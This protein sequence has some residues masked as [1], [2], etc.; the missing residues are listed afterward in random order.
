[1][2]NQPPR[3]TRDH[4]PE[5]IIRRGYVIN[6][7]KSI[8]FAYGFGALETPVFENF[9]VLAVKGGLGEDVKNQIFYFKDKANRELGLR[10]DLTVGMARIVASNPQLPKPFKRYYI[11][12]AWRYE[13][14][15]AGRKR[16][17]VQADIDIVGT[18][19]ME[20]EVECM[21][22]A[23]DCL[24][25]LGFESFTILINNRKI[26]GGLL[27]LAEIPEEITLDT[28][29][30]IDKL[31]KIGEGGVNEELKSLGMGDKQIEKILKLI[32][33]TG[34]CEEVLEKS[35]KMLKGIK[36]AEDGLK[37]MEKIFEF[38]KVYGISDFLVFDL[39]L[40][41]GLDY[42]TGPIFEIKIKTEKQ[43]GS[44]A[45]GGRYDK[46]IELLG[47]KPTPATGISLGIERI[48]EIMRAE[49]MFDL[50]K[51]GVKVFVANVDDKVKNEAIK[52]AQKLRKAGIPCQTDLIG[53]TLTKQLE[54]ADN[55][56]IPHV[57]IVGKREL[58]KSM[59]RLKDM[60]KKTEKEFT[61]EKA[62][63]LL[64]QVNGL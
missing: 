37:E 57:L 16:Q 60:E 33:T 2:K 59:V 46:L 61:Q 42:Y 22:C 43:V 45:G 35:R 34:S 39:S 9:E 8:F 18:E 50:P 4:M 51:T 24:G 7:I 19:S 40:A 44:V 49:N 28:F 25:S 62:I 30:A 31:G 10:P 21:A 17:F 32:T 58:E 23:V 29:R 14:V 54:Y 12:P 6:T 48:V 38:G 3:G 63:E 36:I 15:T 41:R 27:Q 1:M 53:R 5:E 56:G 47:G 20:A 11:A 26:L 55:A 52:I 64:K 13:D